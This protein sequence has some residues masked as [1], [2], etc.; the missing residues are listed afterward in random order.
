MIT[1]DIKHSDILDSGN[2]IKLQH[3][4]DSRTPIKS[5]LKHKNWLFNESCSQSIKYHNAGKAFSISPRHRRF[6]LGLQS[7]FNI[8]VSVKGNWNHCGG[9]SNSRGSVRHFHN[10]LL[11]VVPAPNRSAKVLHFAR[12]CKNVPLRVFKTPCGKKIK[13]DTLRG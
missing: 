7:I 13:K 5:R 10:K 4:V 11:N 12:S 1:K 9:R 8:C 3:N 6:Y 2:S